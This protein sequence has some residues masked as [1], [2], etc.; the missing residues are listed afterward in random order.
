MLSAIVAILRQSES[1]S[2]QVSSLV[3]SDKTNPQAEIHPTDI[4]LLS[5]VS[6]FYASTTSTGF[7]I[8]VFL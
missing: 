1:R 8:L 4:K 6:F 3:S 2:G 7:F 5:E